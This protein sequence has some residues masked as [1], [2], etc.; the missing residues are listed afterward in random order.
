MA[1]KFGCCR[2]FDHILLENI[3][4]LWNL[5]F[6]VIYLIATLDLLQGREIRSTT[7]ADFLK[8]IGHKERLSMWM[9]HLESREQ[10]MEIL[11]EM[12]QWVI[13]YNP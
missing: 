2:A 4:N 5:M 7:M 3:I 1:E 13:T 8:V 9:S 6:T 10:T 12:K 11:A